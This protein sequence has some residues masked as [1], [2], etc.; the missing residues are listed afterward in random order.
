MSRDITNSTSIINLL[1]SEVFTVVVIKM[2]VVM[3][4]VGLVWPT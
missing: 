1:A 4:M 3:V 2:M